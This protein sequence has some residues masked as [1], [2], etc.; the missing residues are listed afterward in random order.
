MKKIFILILVLIL[1]SC[2]NSTKNNNIA[3][4]NTTKKSIPAKSANQ[5]RS[6]HVFNTNTTSGAS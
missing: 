1:I 3:Q 6:A 4:P 2:N 5:F